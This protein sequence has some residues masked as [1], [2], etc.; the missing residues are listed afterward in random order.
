MLSCYQDSVA[1]YIFYQFIIS[2]PYRS[3]TDL[4]NFHHDAYVRCYCHGLRAA[5]SYRSSSSHL[6]QDCIAD[7]FIQNCS[8]SLFCPKPISKVAQV[9]SPNYNH[10]QRSTPWKFPNV[11]PVIAAAPANVYLDM[12]F[13]RMSGVVHDP[14]LPAI[15]PNSPMNDIAYV[16]LSSITIDQGT[17]SYTSQIHFR[18]KEHGWEGMFTWISTESASSDM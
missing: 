11:F 13:Q 4:A 9:N 8:T 6:V 5:M 1:Q 17:V 10:S 2:E 15:I 16:S 12:L 7:N 3:N 18:P 14:C